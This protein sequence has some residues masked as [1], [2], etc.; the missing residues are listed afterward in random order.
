MPA[1]VVE[2]Q[3]L[4]HDFAERPVLR[5]VE[6]RVE[7]GASLALFGENG[8]GKTT[9]LRIVAGLLRPSR[10][11]ARIEGVPALAAG[12]ALRRRVGFL[13]HRPLVWGGLTADENLRLVAKLYGLP[14]DATD[15]GL[16]RV[17]LAA[18]ARVRARDLSQGQRQRLGV[19]RAL[20]GTPDLLLLD[21]PHAGLD[22]AGSELL[23]ALLEELRGSATI[24]LATHDH[25]RGRRLCSTALTLVRGRL[26]R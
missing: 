25:D 9:L 22:R 8:A 24:L 4:E 19:A 21:E 15:A 7:P 2:L 18:S 20:V 14:P 17:G 13:S 5:G 1:P 12:P 10:G 3:R 16:E 6:L 23:D 11:E 26:T